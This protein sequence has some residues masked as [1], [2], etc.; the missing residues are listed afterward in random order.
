[1]SCF[2]C[3][4]SIS[5]PLYAAWQWLR[6]TTG[7]RMRTGGGEDN[8][9]FALSD[10]IMRISYPNSLPSPPPQRPLGEV[11]GGGGGGAPSAKRGGGGG[12]GGDDDDD[13]EGDASSTMPELRSTR[14]SGGN[15]DVLLRRTHLSPA[16]CLPDATMT[17]DDDDD[18][19]MARVSRGGGGDVRPGR[20]GDDN[21]FG[22]DDDDDDDDDDDVDDDD[23]DERGDGRYGVVEDDDG[24]GGRVPSSAATAASTAPSP[25]LLRDW[26]PRGDDGGFSI[27]RDGGPAPPA[28]DG[29]A[30]REAARGHR[31]PPLPRLFGRKLR[32]L[33]R[34]VAAD[35][36]RRE[37]CGALLL[38]GALVAAV[39]AL[40]A[41][42]SKGGGGGG[43]GSGGL[44]PSAAAAIPGGNDLSEY[45]IPTS[46][47]PT[48][49]GGGGGGPPRNQGRALE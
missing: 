7:M 14:W 35:K 22:I 37:R 5:L 4:E 42:L 34:D 29:D 10:K 19:E 23:D 20:D 26:D 12:G 1:M 49:A 6:W 25:V 39:V 2:S 41:A 31:L 36:A 17:V 21:R 33:A 27:Y 40:S 47:L 32:S 48:P 16:S 28:S 8:P 9:P 44:D 15:D 45:D 11:D 38:L 24:G 13:D 46:G 3:L 30:R 43:G 18:V